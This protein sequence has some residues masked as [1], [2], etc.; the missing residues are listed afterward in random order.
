LGQLNP[1]GVDGDDTR[2]C[3]GGCTYVAKLAAIEN[4]APPVGRERRGATEL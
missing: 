3:A 1:A 4:A 2:I